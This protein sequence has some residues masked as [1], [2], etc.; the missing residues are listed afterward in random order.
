MNTAD[1]YRAELIR[2]AFGDRAH[3]TKVADLHRLNQYA[4]RLA[5]S[6]RAQSIL[7]A[8]GY[9]IAGTSFVELASS[10]PDYA[11]GI[12]RSIFRRGP[13]PDYRPRGDI[14]DIWT[15]R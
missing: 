10:V 6:E 11:P 5:E 1:I 4:E 14:F 15:T 8:K 2:A 12:L 13:A 7:R 9:G 3:E